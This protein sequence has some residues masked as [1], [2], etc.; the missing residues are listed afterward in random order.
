MP[1]HVFES[2]YPPRHRLV[3]HRSTCVFCN[4][5]RGM[6]GSYAGPSAAWHGPFES[7][8][9]ARALLA[10]LASTRH[11]DLR[12]VRGECRFCAPETG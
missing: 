11:L 2:W 6:R 5:G 4:D 3:I 10:D 9:Q 7:L 1:Y 8:E 12:T